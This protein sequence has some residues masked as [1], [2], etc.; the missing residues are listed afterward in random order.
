M[1]LTN[2]SIFEND[3]F[4]KKRVYLHRISVNTHGRVYLHRISVNTHGRVYLLSK[5]ILKTFHFFAAD[6]DIFFVGRRDED[7][8]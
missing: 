5:P 8:F 4:N 7:D 2:F 3:W 6:Q 1:S